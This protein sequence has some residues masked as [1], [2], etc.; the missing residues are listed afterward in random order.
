MTEK[1][2]YEYEEIKLKLAEAMARQIL[3]DERSY[4]LEAISDAKDLLF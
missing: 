2:A 1:S 3:N 4:S